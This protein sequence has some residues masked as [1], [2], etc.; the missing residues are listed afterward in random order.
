M[1]RTYDKGLGTLRFGA[2]AGDKLSAGE[3]SLLSILSALSAIDKHT[4][5]DEGE[6]GDG[7]SFA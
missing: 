5:W 4:A 1:Y 7:Y 6:E 3:C 2:G